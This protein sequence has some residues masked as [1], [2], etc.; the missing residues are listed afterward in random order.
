MNKRI[1]RTE[2]DMIAD[3]RSN[4]P[5]IEAC[6]IIE[7][8]NKLRAKGRELVSLASDDAKR[9]IVEEYPE[10]EKKPVDLAEAA[11]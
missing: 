7:R 11:E 1:K 10:F 5:V 6:Y 4:G 8:L 2:A 3:K 9:Y